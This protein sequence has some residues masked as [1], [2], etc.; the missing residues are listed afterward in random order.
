MGAGA[1]T[2][3]CKP[4]NIRL[5][6]IWFTTTLK[7]SNSAIHIFYL[8]SY[9]VKEI[10]CFPIRPKDQIHWVLLAV[11]Q[12]CICLW[13]IICCHILTLFHYVLNSIGYMKVLC[14]LLTAQQM[15]TSLLPW[16]CSCCFSVTE[17][18][19]NVVAKISFKWCD[20]CMVVCLYVYIYLI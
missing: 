20:M 10:I 15:L 17:S 6:L 8:K 14:S 19:H 7:R 1:G 3:T 2:T 5:G 13:L 18:S 9:A 11:L 16:C 4:F 12:C